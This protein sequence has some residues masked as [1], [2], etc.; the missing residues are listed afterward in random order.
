[1]GEYQPE[2]RFVLRDVAL[3]VWMEIVHLAQHIPLR[4]RVTVEGAK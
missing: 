3:S 2:T 1:M 4:R